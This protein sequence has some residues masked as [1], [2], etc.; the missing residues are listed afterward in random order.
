VGLPLGIAAKMILNGEIKKRGVILP[1]DSAI[2]N[3]VLS[4]LKEEFQI[5][6]I[7]SEHIF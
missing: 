1:V 4:E 5:N 3:P 7:E 6:F 2:Y